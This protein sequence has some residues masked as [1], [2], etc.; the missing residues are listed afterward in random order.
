MHG[1]LGCPDVSRATPTPGD[2]TRP[3][4]AATSLPD[5]RTRSGR[6]TVGAASRPFSARSVIASTLLG[7]HPP[8]LSPRRLV[9]SCALFGIGDGAARVAL[10]RMLAAGEVTLDDGRY[11]LAGRLL[12]RQTRQADSRSGLP[13]ARWDG[14]WIVHVVT[15]ENRDAAAR[16]ELR[17]VMRRLH[18]PELRE[19]TWLR[20]DNLDGARDPGDAALVQEQCT[21]LRGARPADPNEL[22]HGLFDLE[23]WAHTARRLV[24]ALEAAATRL[25]DGD[26]T[27][28][29]M[30]F[31]RN[32]EVLRHL[33]AD[34][35]LPDELLPADWPGDELRATFDRFDATFSL[36][37][38]RA[39]RD[40][41]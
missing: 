9:R 23:A 15:A 4:P 29:A 39:M 27:V 34:P 26:D 31:A 33:L 12:E 24:D 13:R 35:L 11:A 32:A 21:T 20:P 16:T 38:Q 37:W 2:P 7:T 41:P 22:V 19:G 30:A 6:R 28:L 14:S 36:A 17:E 10:S 8:R 3:S 18:V 25:P 5:A 40:S 1:L